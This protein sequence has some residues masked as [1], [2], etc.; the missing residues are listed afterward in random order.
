MRHDPKDMEGKD[1]MGHGEKMDEKKKKKTY[2]R[3]ALMIATSTIIMH[4]LT[5]TNVYQIDHIYFSETRFFLSLMMG[6]MMTV[7]MLL[8]MWKMYTDKTWNRMIIIGSAVVF[9][10][11]FW[12]MRSQTTVDDSS[13]MRAM[14][15]HHSIAILTSENA[16]IT[17]P[18]AKE[19]ADEIIRTQKEEIEEMKRLL[20]KLKNAP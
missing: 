5:Y 12:L 16:Q 15:P 8:F 1:S 4:L 2:G 3:F 18:E 14:I 9:V 7:V 17:D 20:E 6:A 10:A 13:W 19:L 11:A